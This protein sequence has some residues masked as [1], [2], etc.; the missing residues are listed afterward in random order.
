MCT[1]KLSILLLYFHQCDSLR[2]VSLKY[3]YWQIF[4]CKPHMES[5]HYALLISCVFTINEVSKITFYINCNI[6]YFKTSGVFYKSY[7][8][9]ILYYKKD[10]F[11]THKSYELSL[12]ASL[13][14]LILNINYDI[15]CIGINC[16]FLKNLILVWNIGVFK[17]LKAKFELLNSTPKIR[18][19]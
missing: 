9:W 11:K 17:I 19:F 7:Y 1:L 12:N 10:I 4:D 16:I 2:Y 6:V 13:K 8:F 3:T 5:C 18:A 15:R 14:I